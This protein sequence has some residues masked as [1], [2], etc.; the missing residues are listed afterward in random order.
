MVKV[1]F[2]SFASILPRPRHVGGNLGN[3]DC[4]VLPVEGIGSDVIQE[5]K[6]V[7]NHAAARA[8]ES[9]P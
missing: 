9:M 2:G 4:P 8:S 7:S 1:S 3:A 5:P 6:R